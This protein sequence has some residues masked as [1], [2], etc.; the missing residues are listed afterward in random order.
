MFDEN[1]LCPS[2]LRLEI[3]ETVLMENAGTTS[4][5]LRQLKSIGVQLAIDDFGTGFSSL[6]YLHKFPFDILKID[7][8]FVTRMS[9]D[10][11]SLSIVK[12]ITTL[13]AELGKD[14]VAEGIETVEHLDLLNEFSCRLG[15]GYHFSRPVPADQAEL[16]LKDGLL[17]KSGQF[18][19]IGNP[20]EI[21]AT[22][23][24]GYE[25]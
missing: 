11:E 14:V 24:S 17:S 6:S 10:K 20:Q 7:R 21:Q 3:T 22:I 8:S 16:L 19:I 23:E 13:A 4:D 12:T 1:L 9:T 25:M 2:T 15:Q 5:M 18:P